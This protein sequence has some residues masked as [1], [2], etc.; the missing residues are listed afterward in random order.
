[1]SNNFK[2]EVSKTKVDK[3]STF[4]DLI[5]DYKDLYP[6]EI[7]IN[8]PTDKRFIYRG[9]SVSSYELLPSVFRKQQ[10]GNIVNRKYLSLTSEKN[11]LEEFISWG[12]RVNV[13][14]Y[15][16]ILLQLII[17]YNVN[18]QI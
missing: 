11:L 6:N 5:E 14:S 12:V 13:G 9:C 8:N 16:F 18:L 3:L 10:D 7:F 1:M 15:P 17:L 4:I 2:I